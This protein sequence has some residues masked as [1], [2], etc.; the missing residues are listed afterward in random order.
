MFERFF[1]VP[2]Q[3]KNG[4]GLGLP[5]AREIGV[6]HGGRIGVKSAPGQGSSFF[7]VLKPAPAAGGPESSA[8]QGRENGPGAGSK[9]LVAV[10]PSPCK[11]QLS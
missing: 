1:R 9:A 3:A 7:M 5:I 4:A 10:A 6:A 11:W 2:G 8:P